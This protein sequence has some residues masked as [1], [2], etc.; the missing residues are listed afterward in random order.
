MS[1]W[2]ATRTTRWRGPAGVSMMP[3]GWKSRTALPSGIGTWSCAWKETAA[4]SSLWSVTGGSSS[5]RSTVRWVSTPTRTRLGS[6]ASENSSRSASAASGTLAACSATIEPL[7][8]ALTAATKPGWMSRPTMS[9][10]A[11]R[12]KPFRLGAPS[13]RFGERRLPSLRFGEERLE[14]SFIVGCRCGESRIAPL[15]GYRLLSTRPLVE[16]V[17]DV[18]IDQ[19]TARVDRHDR[20]EREEGAERHGGLAAGLG[21]L[22]GDDHSAHG[23]AG[24]QRD[25]Q[26]GGDGGAEEQPHHARELHVAHA[27]PARVGEHGE[28]QEAAGGGAGDQAA[29]LAGRV[30]RRAESDREQRSGERQPVRDQTR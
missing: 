13:L 12:P 22:A 20:A 11:R 23:D 30:E 7:T 8:R 3:S 21:A 2:A 15:G 9:A 5:S 17:I 14:G 25:E 28:E 10:P 26:R 4:A 27:H 29:G 24:E 1:R 18:D 16:E 19:R 6:F